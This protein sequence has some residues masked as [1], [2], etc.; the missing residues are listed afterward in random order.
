MRTE[1][2]LRRGSWKGFTYLNMKSRFLY[3]EDSSWALNF[4]FAAAAA[5]Q[6]INVRIGPTSFIYAKVKAGMSDGEHAFQ[7]LRSVLDL[8]QG[9]S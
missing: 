1:Y 4:T 6:P 3:E 5:P 9:S 2:G 8:R 7:A